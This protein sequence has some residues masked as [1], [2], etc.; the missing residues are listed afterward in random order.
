MKN[1]ITAISA[2]SLV[3]L[4]I[5]GCQNSAVT[6]TTETT[7]KTTPSATTT[8]TT[9]PVSELTFSEGDTQMTG[10][11]SSVIE[12]MQVDPSVGPDTKEVSTQEAQ[13]EMSDKQLY[14]QALT[15]KNT[16]YC[17]KIQNADV[18]LTCADDVQAAK[19]AK[20]SPKSVTTTDSGTTTQ[21]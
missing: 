17:D 21:Q 10:D 1:K 20:D 4:L 2:L 3:I 18:R 19:E 14:A 8:V 5:A 16:T 12:N 7:A 9:S 6:P 11:E 13:N 15:E